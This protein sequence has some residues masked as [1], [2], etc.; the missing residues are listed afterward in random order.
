MPTR[1]V[2]ANTRV[3]RDYRREK[4]LAAA[5]TPNMVTPITGSRFDAFKAWAES[6]TIFKGRLRGKRFHIPDFQRKLIEPGLDGDATENW[7]ICGRKNGKSGASGLLGTSHLAG[8]LN[9]PGVAI[10]FLSETGHLSRE[11]YDWV[12]GLVI[13]NDIKGLRFV[14]SPTPTIYGWNGSKM[15][16]LADSPNQG[17]GLDLNLAIIDEVG[18]YRENRRK[19]LNSMRSA[20]S[21]S[22]GRIFA[23]TV[24]GYSDFVVDALGRAHL[25]SMNV[26][27]Y[28]GDPQ[29]PIDSEENW[30]LA[31][32]G[33][34][35][36]IKSMAY[37]RHQAAMAKETPADLAD[38]KANDLNL[39][40]APDAVELVP[41]DYIRALYDDTVE[42]ANEPVFLGIDFGG[43]TSMTAAVAVGASTGRL[44]AWGVFPRGLGLRERGLR[45]GVGGK[46]Q[47]MF[48]RGEL[49][50]HP[51]LV[52]DYKRFVWDVVAEI[53]SGGCWIQNVGSDR[54]NVAF[55][56]QALVELGLSESEIWQPRGT[57]AG[58]I[59]DG[60]ADV[61]SFQRCVA[62]KRISLKPSLLFE[63]GI[64]AARLRMDA[65]GNYAVDKRR[66]NHRQD[67]AVAACIAV[68]FYDRQA[69][70]RRSA[71]IIGGLD[72]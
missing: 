48:E 54:H 6:L 72:D 57:G 11:A 35:V 36:G 59:A 44:R 37:M 8:P 12:E 15:V 62:Q 66:W 53:E 58:K 21:A 45:D 71:V 42:L 16:F 18:F 23:M 51:G 50:V 64:R 17:Q 65:G 31:N 49:W 25:P 56:R 41:M 14:K 7:L 39:P 2:K 67:I 30:H 26:A 28:Q 20:V 52:V 40:G 55:L 22:D 3:K 10:A 61:R 69:P 32:P 29:L 43:E 13:A 63:E 70:E 24:R 27:H 4:R 9:E 33:L 47:A 60:S 19:Q 34:A 38:F 46:Y 68:G 5:T 1:G